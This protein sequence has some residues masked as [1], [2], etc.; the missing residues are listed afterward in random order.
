MY[1]TP[2]QTGGSINHCNSCIKRTNLLLVFQE[3]DLII[4]LSVFL[5]HTKIFILHSNS[6]ISGR[7][8]YVKHAAADGHSD[9]DWNCR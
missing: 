1:L 7:A 3:K 6:G 8:V 9:R 4:K 5:G 2:I